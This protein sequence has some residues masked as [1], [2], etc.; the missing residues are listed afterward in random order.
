MNI[1]IPLRERIADIV[2]Y[3]FAIIPIVGIAMGGFICTP[4]GFGV[5]SCVMG[6]AVDSIMNFFL[7]YGFLIVFGGFFVWIPVIIVASV[8]SIK[9][10]RKAG[11]KIIYSPPFILLYLFVVSVLQG[12]IAD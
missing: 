1:P 9:S 3:V 10:R 5:H 2:I 4:E 6:P 11:R 8:I 7:S 12:I